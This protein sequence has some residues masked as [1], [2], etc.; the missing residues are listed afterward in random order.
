MQADLWRCLAWGIGLAFILSLITIVFI[1]KADRIDHGFLGLI[2]LL[3]HVIFLF[4]LSLLI[5]AA[6]PGFSIKLAVAIFDG[7]L[8]LGTKL[9][10]DRFLDYLESG[11]GEDESE[12][13][14]ADDESK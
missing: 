9:T 14:E 12:T 3:V 13:D 10:S 5:A 8:A 4:L 1:L 2:F 11:P 7:I 6:T